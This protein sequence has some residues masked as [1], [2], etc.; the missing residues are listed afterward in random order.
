MKI[1]GGDDRAVV[2]VLLLIRVNSSLG[3]SFS[4]KEV[5][6]SLSVMIMVEV[7]VAVLAARLLRNPLIHPWNHEACKG[8][9]N[10]RI[11]VGIHEPPM[12]AFRFFG[13]AYETPNMMW[14]HIRVVKNVSAKR[15]SER[16]RGNNVP[17]PRMKVG[18]S[19]IA[20]RQNI[21]GH[22]NDKAYS[23]MKM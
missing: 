11:I 22:E 8:N 5:D 12:A 13:T 1:K 7:E 4:P 6:P 17:K 3:L 14:K 20:A 18:S 10:A 19:I 16:S 23:T 15:V 21:W 2:V 9:I